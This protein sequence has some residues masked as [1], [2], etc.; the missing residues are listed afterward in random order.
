VRR[1]QKGPQGSEANQK[2]QGKEDPDPGAGQDVK[3]PSRPVN[4]QSDQG[5]KSDRCRG[6]EEYGIP[7]V[8]PGAKTLASYALY[9]QAGQK[10]VQG[11]KSHQ[12]EGEVEGIAIHFPG[13]SCCS[14]NQ[15]RY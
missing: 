6:G 2:L 8:H 5:K 10:A 14:E 9:R 12:I 1:I 3:Q 11:G 13:T 4:D 7:G 15:F